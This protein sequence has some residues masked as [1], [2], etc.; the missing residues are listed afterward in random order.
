MCVLVDHD[1]IYEA[2]YD[3]LNQR[4][5]TRTSSST[6]KVKRMLRLAIGARSQLCPV[7]PGFRIVVIAEVPLLMT[8][9]IKHRVIR[10]PFSFYAVSLHEFYSYTYVFR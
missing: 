10:S 5:I 4:Y 6:G 8:F 3:V 7:A 2:L 1:L 9:S